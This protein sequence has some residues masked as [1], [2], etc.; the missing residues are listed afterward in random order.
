MKTATLNLVVDILAFVAFMLLTATGV[1]LHL[2]LP[3]GSGHF[4][5]LWGMDRHQWGQIHFWIAVLLM[6][7]LV[8]HLLLHWRWIVSSIRG[9]PRQ[10]DSGPRVALALVALVAL[11][12]VS[13]APFF[14]E[15]KHGGE[16]PHKLR[17]I[18]SE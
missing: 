15:V 4:T 1:L 17:T 5:V 18:K 6:I 8:V 7:S 16:P 11:L 10:R 13:I 14:A 12:A 9:R 3:P 2:I